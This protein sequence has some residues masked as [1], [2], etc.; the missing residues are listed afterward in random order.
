VRRI[1]PDVRAIP[2]LAHFLA[3]KPKNRNE[4]SHR[5][6]SAAKP[7]PQWGAWAGRRLVT[8]TLRCGQE[9]IRHKRPPSRKR[10]P[11]LYFRLLLDLRSDVLKEGNCHFSARKSAVALSGWRGDKNRKGRPATAGSALGP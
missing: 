3:T 5:L 9:A 8:R 1:V 7:Q 2:A 4:F 10:A 6:R 11:S